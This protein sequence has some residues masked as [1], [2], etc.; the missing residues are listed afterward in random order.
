MARLKQYRWKLTEQVTIEETG[1]VLNNPTFRGMHA[2]YDMQKETA[3]II[4]AAREEGSGHDTPYQI[5][6]VLSGD[7]E[8]LNTNAVSAIIRYHFPNSEEIIIK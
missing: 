7:E 1:M 6:H 4:L 2:N 5:E 8:G 3:T